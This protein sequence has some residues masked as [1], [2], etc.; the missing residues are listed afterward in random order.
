MKGD[1]NTTLAAA[2]CHKVAIDVPF[3][4]DGVP[5]SGSSADSS[6]LSE[7]GVRDNSQVTTTHG[8]GRRLTNQTV[9]SSPFIPAVK[10]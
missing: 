2:D 7:G 4:I 5:I 10:T 3:Y 9:E 1:V 8:T 6:T